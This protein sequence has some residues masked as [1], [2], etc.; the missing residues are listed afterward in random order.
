MERVPGFGDKAVFHALAAARKVDLGSR[1]RLLERPG[2]GQG[3]VDVAGRAA[4]SDQ[5]A[6]RVPLLILLGLRAAVNGAP[7]RRAAAQTFPKL[8]LAL[9]LLGADARVACARDAEQHAHLA[10][11][12]QQAC[13]AGREKRQADAG[14]GQRGRDDADV[15]EH[16]P[17]DLCRDADAEH[18]AEIIRR[19]QR[20]KMPW[21]ISAPNSTMHSTAP[22]KP[23]SSQTMEKMK[24]LVASGSQR[25]FWR[26]L[27]MPSPVSPPEAME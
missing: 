5:N 14:V 23:S 9:L 26:L 3:R 24:S 27:P 21:T 1:V 11:K 12:Q 6:H 8:P 19:A 2:N 10:Q 18:G 4:G 7:G 22:R 17:G 25:C 20:N 15:A 16:L 13:A